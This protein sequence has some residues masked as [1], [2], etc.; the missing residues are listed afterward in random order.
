MR[1]S[2]DEQIKQTIAIAK[3]GKTK[4]DRLKGVTL[5]IKRTITSIAVK[6]ITTVTN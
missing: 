2:R 5:L 6:R 1:K 3:I 4:P